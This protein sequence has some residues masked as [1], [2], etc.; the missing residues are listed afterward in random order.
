MTTLSATVISS[1]ERSPPL[2]TST[3]VEAERGAEVLSL[4]RSE[5]PDVIFLDLMLPDV[6]GFEILKRLKS[7][8][9]TKMIP[10][11]IHTSMTLDDEQ[12]ESLAEAAEAIIFK[13]SKSR[14]AAVAEIRDSLSK[15]GLFPPAHVNAAEL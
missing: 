1:R 8:D 15:A 12:R 14:E 13:G 3:V 4:A 10:V 11:I 5:R 7:D 6:T 2:A 9:T